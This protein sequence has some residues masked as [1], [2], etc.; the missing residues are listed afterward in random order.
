MEHFHSRIPGWCSPEQFDLYKEVAH[1]FPKNSRIV[2][3]G[4]W[5]GKSTSFMAVEMLAAKN[6]LDF[7]VVDHWLGSSEHQ[8]LPETA[9]VYESFIKNMEPVQELLTVIKKPSIEAAK[10]FEDSSLDFVFIDAEHTYDALISDITAWL[11]KLKPGG[12]LAGDDWD[13][14]N[15]VDVS[16][17]VTNLLKN[18]ELRGRVWVYKIHS[19]N[20]FKFTQDQYLNLLIN[21]DKT[22]ADTLIIGLENNQNSLKCM[23]RAKAYCDR[24]GQPNSFFWGYDGTDGKNIKTPEHLKNNNAMQLLKVMD[25]SLSIPEV[26]C[27]LSHIAAWVHCMVINKPV[28]ILEHDALMLR[29]FKELTNSNTLEYLGHVG[30]LG[31]QLKLDDPELVNKYIESNQHLNKKHKKE[32]ILP[33]MQMVNENYLLVLGLHAYAID[34][35]MAKRLYSYVLKHGLVNPADAIIEQH[36]FSLTQTGIYAV[37]AIDSEQTTTIGSSRNNRKYTYNIPGVGI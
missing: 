2:E 33:M 21:R 30:E 26:C 19:I 12:T 4:A 28:V 14:D 29:P 10:D 9:T 34:P 7:Y 16:K 25:T 36:E 13:N 31:N 22:I 8:H 15:F 24:V 23:R 6:T 27:F 17:A 5:L 18:V 1:T 20:T 37:Q 35:A 32:L 11:P 3:V